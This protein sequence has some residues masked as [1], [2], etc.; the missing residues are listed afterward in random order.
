MNLVNDMSS[1]HFGF[2]VESND[3]DRLKRYHAMK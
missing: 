1:I 3:N 2:E